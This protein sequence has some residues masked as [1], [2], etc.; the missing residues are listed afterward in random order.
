MEVLNVIYRCKEG[1]REEFLNAIL[2]EGIDEACRAE[3]G[4]ICY[5]YFLAAQSDDELFLLE[6]WADM[7]ALE[8]H[9]GQAHFARL[10]ELKEQYVAD[11]AIDRFEV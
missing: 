4:N 7:E 10:G 2:S 1:K 5:D 8:R 3:Q 9:W 6:K 11:T